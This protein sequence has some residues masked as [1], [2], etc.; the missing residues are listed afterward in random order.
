MKQTQI[1]EVKP[2]A[3][4]RRREVIRRTGL[5]NSALYV[6]IKAG[7]FPKSFSLGGNLAGWL[8]SD[9]DAWIHNC[10]SGRKA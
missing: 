4:L 8:E 2:P 6:R 5:S 1:K 9:V 7:E 3:V 10:A